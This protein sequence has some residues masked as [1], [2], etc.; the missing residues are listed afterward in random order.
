[1]KGFVLI[2]TSEKR[3]RAKT[4]FKDDR[5]SILNSIADKILERFENK[6]EA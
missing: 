2:P 1:M 4:N 5:F 6:N 3:R